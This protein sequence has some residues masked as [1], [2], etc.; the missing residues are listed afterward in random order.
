M[1]QKAETQGLIV[2][3]LEF[4]RMNEIEQSII[5]KKLKFE[6]RKAL[7]K[8]VT[9]RKYK[10]PELNKSVN[11]IYALAEELNRIIEA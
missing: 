1:F 7:G 11:E 6:E 8:T 5:E 9:L 4:Q 10:K 2:P 3:E